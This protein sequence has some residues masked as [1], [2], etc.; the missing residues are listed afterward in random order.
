MQL[1]TLVHVFFTQVQ[2][3]QKGSCSIYSFCLFL[4]A[5]FILLSH[6]PLAPM[7]LFYIYEFLS[8]KISFKLSRT[9]DSLLHLMILTLCCFIYQLLRYSLGISSMAHNLNG[10]FVSIT[11]FFHL[12]TLP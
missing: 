11:F 1:S 4:L 7:P 2:C 10:T 3:P 6:Y 9:M 12:S 5:L 8:P